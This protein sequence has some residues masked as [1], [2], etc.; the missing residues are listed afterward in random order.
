MCLFKRIKK[1]QSSQNQ[2]IHYKMN[3]GIRLAKRIASSGLCSRRKSEELIMKGLVK[4][5]GVL[6]TKP[7]INVKED[8]K[9][10]IKNNILPKTIFKIYMYYKPPGCLTTSFDPQ[11]IKLIFICISK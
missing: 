6:I 8:D 3:E 10:E 4:V 5:N 7:Y 1:Y 11:R 9:I 2:A